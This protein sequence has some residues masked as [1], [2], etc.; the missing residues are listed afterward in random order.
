MQPSLAELQR[1]LAARIVGGEGSDLDAW[2][3]V[4]SDADPA[5]RV[6]VYVQGYL[7]RSDSRCAGNAAPTRLRS[8]SSADT[9]F[10]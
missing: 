5:A 6:A 3:C 1:S 9:L 4:P 10:A 8:R 2:I 7:A